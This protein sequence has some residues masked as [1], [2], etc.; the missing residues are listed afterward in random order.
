MLDLQSTLEIEYHM[1]IT[2]ALIPESKAEG[3][4]AALG[5]HM[6]IFCKILSGLRR[7]APMPAK[8]RSFLK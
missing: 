8:I 7:L 6:S 1:F 5:K 2:H 4:G 3:G